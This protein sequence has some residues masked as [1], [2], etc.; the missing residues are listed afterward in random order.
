[1]VKLPHNGYLAIQTII[2]I[3]Q[4]SAALLGTGRAFVI[5]CKNA[6]QSVHYT[7]RNRFPY[8]CG[9]FMVVSL[10]DPPQNQR[11]DCC[12]HRNIDFSISRAA[13]IIFKI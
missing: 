7:E 1:M 13:K 3:A 8:R 4:Q 11:Y 12:F 2:D 6:S 5:K 10:L 9:M